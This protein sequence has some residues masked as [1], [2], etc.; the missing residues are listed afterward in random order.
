MDYVTKAR[1]ASRRWRA[2]QGLPPRSDLS[3]VRSF[4]SSLPK[5]EGVGQREAERLARE[6]STTETIETTK[7]R[8]ARGRKSR[9]SRTTPWHPTYAH[10]W[11]D[12]LPGLGTRR[13]GPFDSCVGCGRGSWARYGGH[14]P[15]C[16]CAIARG[17]A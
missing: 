13:V 7:E 6:C 10:P 3:S 12:A 9:E 17:G 15:C 2:A 14:V 5:Q 8:E 1:E 11:P 4:P 16:P